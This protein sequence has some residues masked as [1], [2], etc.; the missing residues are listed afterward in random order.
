M[1]PTLTSN[2][3][4]NPIITLLDDSVGGI[5]RVAAADAGYAAQGDVAGGAAPTG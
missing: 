4:Q 3:C 1:A 5:G 2:A